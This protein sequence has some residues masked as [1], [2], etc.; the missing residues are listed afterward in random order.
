MDAQL[1]RPESKGEGH[2]V[3]QDAPPPSLAFAVGL[4]QRYRG[5]LV[6][7][8]A[9]FPPYGTVVAALYL[10]GYWWKIGVNPFY[11]TSVADLLAA[12]LASL[13]ATFML[14]C[15]GGC[16]GVFIGE[17]TSVSEKPLGKL[18]R[19]ASL[20]ISLAFLVFTAFTWPDA[21]WFLGGAGVCLMIVALLIKN[22]MAPL[23]RRAPWIFLVAL[24]LVVYVPFAMY[25]L[26]RMRA[27]E[28][29][30]PHK[31]RVLDQRQSQIPIESKGPITYLGTLG[32]CHLLYA[33]EEES[34]ALPRVDE[35]MLVLGPPRKL[36]QA[37][38]R[39]YEP[40]N[41]SEPSQHRM[42][43]A[44]GQDK[45]SSVSAKRRP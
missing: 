17:A 8:L 4:A 26:A 33:V 7:L 16:I 28:A 42:L 12:T 38:K 13:P 34:V 21:L 45:T 1:I 40:S 6:P 11:L 41:S 10:A 20:S 27:H 32:D 14:L 5:L 30:D 25:G 43:E 3:K 23:I 31:S 2:V 18:S 29:M 19:W 24:F 39:S 37:A 36:T 44:P 22:G 15:M 35:A 9:L